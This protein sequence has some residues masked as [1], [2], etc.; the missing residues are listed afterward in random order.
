V[1]SP[2]DYKKWLSE[3]TT[4]AQDI[5]AAADAEK[6]VEGATPATDGT[7]KVIDTVKAVVDTVKAAV[8]KVA[9]K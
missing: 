8:A 7:A 5:K 2:E 4:L 3:K 9:I 6:P 1:D